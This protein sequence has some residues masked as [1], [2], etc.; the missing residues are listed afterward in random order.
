MDK[1]AKVGQVLGELESEIM[2]ILWQDKHALSVRQVTGTLQL[3]RKIAYTT[4]MTVMGR[5]VEKRLLRQQVTHG[6]AFVY[7]TVYSKEKFLTKITRQII[8]NLTSSF[9][10]MA[11]AH[12]AK[13]V[14][15]IPEE[16]KRKLLKILNEVTK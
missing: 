15:N 11:I 14:E 7:K 16:K 1:G 9:G 2:N 6:R 12:F 8:K 10:D 4:V 5:L 3:K 13:E